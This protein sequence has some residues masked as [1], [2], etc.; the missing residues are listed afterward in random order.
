MN[1]VLTGF[2]ASGKTTVGAYLSERCCRKMLDTDKLVEEK[3]DMTIPDIFSKLG[4]DY[5]R[6]IESEVIEE[7][8]RMDSLIIAT[9]GGA[10]LNTKNIE[11]LRQNGVVVNLAPDER[12]VRT[13]LSG[14]NST[15]PLAAGQDIDD[16]LKRYED[17]KPFYDNCDVKI[18]ITPEMTVREIAEDILKKV[19]AR[20]LEGENN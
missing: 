1:I 12:T 20:L 6:R 17:R 13:R 5:F 19:N 16:I 10:V 2:M 9:G 3:V 8:S 11:I 14:E 15:R 4:E 18:K 7:I